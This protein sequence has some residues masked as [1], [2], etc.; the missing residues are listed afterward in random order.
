MPNIFERRSDTAI[1]DELQELVLKDLL[2][3]AGGLEE[4]LDELYA[5]EHYLVG[6]LAPQQSILDADEAS[7]GHQCPV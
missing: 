4:E 6:M 1:R 3:P 5:R 2:S 7:P